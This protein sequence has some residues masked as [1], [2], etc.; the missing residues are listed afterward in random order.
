MG[1]IPLSHTLI[2]AF[3]SSL[4]MGQ[5][6]RAGRHWAS[7]NFTL[8]PGSALYAYQDWLRYRATS[9]FTNRG[10]LPTARAS[11]AQRRPAQ[12]RK[13]PD[14]AGTPHRRLFRWFRQPL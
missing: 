7:D 13:L 11:L 5:V 6:D 10:T 14:R 9:R 4:S 8:S 1:F 12:A 2:D 3:L